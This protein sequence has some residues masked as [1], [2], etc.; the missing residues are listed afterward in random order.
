[1]IAGNCDRFMEL[2]VP[3]VIGRSSCFGLVFRQSFENHSIK[4][5]VIV[6]FALFTLNSPLSL[7]R[8]VVRTSNVVISNCCLADR[9]TIVDLWCYRHGPHFI[10]SLVLVSL[11]ERSKS[12][13]S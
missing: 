8:V 3:V 1:M 5:Y 6:A 4:Y 2:F 10:D 11:L 9:I 7:V 13:S 12:Q